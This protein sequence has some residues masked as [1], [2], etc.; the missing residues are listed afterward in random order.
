MSTAIYIV[1]SPLQMLYALE[2]RS[3]F[4]AETNVI[5]LLRNDHIPDRQQIDELIKELTWDAT[6]EL[7]W[8]A[9]MPSFIKVVKQFFLSYFLNV[10]YRK[11]NRIFLGDFAFALATFLKHDD[12]YLIS[13]GNKIIWQKELYQGY[14]SLDLTRFSLINKFLKWIL[15]IST[16]QKIRVK[17]FT[18][19]EIS[20][21]S[22][23][24]EIHNFD[25]LKNKIQSDLIRQ[26][27]DQ[28]VYFLGSYLSEGAWTQYTSES[29]Y[30]DCMLKIFIYYKNRGKN[31]IYVPHRYE[32]KVK[33]GRLKS[34][35]PDLEFDVF[36]RGVELEFFR[37][38]LK[39]TWVASFISTALYTLKKIYPSCQCDAFFLDRKYFLPQR[40]WHHFCLIYDYYEKYLNVNRELLINDE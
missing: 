33:L 13:D 17:Y 19:F 11:F 37:R 36:E 30:M 16:N 3:R 20:D 34:K 9:K 28:V 7:A 1:A 12:F 6:Y 27:D 29:Y 40:F 2:A 35:L 24:A 23:F 15:P 38:N 8:P 26:Q 31:L 25:W 18:P 32:C 4:S 10:K 22:V 39:P 5:C 21:T 14:L